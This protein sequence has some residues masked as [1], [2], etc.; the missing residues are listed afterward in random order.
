MANAQWEGQ[1]KKVFMSRLRRHRRM[2][3][4][5]YMCGEPASEGMASCEPCRRVI[6]IKQ[7]WKKKELPLPEES[8]ELT[9]GPGYGLGKS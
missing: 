7:P 2:L 6:S 5:C 8:F 1:P 9:E 4:L 3:R